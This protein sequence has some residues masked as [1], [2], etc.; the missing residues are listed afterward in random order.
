MKTTEQ[1]RRL[2]SRI[3]QLHAEVAYWQD[4]AE[5]RKGVIEQL[6]RGKR[7]PRRKV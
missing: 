3:E 4:I 6:R 5:N 2:Q 7:E 1:I